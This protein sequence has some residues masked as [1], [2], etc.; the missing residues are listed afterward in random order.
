MNYLRQTKNSSKVKKV[1]K[2]CVSKNLRR[3]TTK[4][5]WKDLLQSASG[6]KSGRSLWQSRRG[7]VK[8]FINQFCATGL[9]L[10]SL[11]FSDLLRGHRK[12]PALRERCPY[13]EFFWS[14][15]SPNAGKYGPEKLRIW[16]L[17]TQC[18]ELQWYEMG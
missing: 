7:V 18:S 15:V 6:I 5:Y 3:R 1:I 11:W 10:Y 2:K 9:F 12:R 17:F 16:T 4:I 14:V 8:K 13:S